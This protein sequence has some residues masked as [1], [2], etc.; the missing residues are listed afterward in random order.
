[1]KTIVIAA[2]TLIH[3]LPHPFG[4]SSVGALALYGGAYGDKRFSWLV[5]FIPLALG[6]LIT[7][8]YAPVVLVFVFAGYALSTLAGRWFLRQPRSR[9]Q[10]GLAITT[11]ALIFYVVSN[12]AIWWVGYDP[13]TLAGLMQCYVNGLP[14]LGVAAL[15][16]AV[17]CFVL[18][19]LHAW[20]SRREAE[21]VPA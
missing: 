15:A 18:F 19:G 9:G 7:G 8:L 1:M 12:F 6:L 11:G 20:L 4:V 2:A 17:Y 3:L 13:A 10:F 5:P 14:Y 16:D 21:P